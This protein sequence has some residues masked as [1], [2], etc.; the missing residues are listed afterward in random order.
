MRRSTKVNTKLAL[1]N[2]TVLDKMVIEENE[3]RTIRINDVLRFISQ[4]D[5]GLNNK[6][7]RTIFK[8][9]EIVL[10]SGVGEIGFRLALL[11]KIA[12]AIYCLCKTNVL[13]Q[14]I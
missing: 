9:F 12:N 14:K 4:I 3:C 2:Q 13:K 7:K 11:S 5:N 1:P 10:S 6:K 8:F